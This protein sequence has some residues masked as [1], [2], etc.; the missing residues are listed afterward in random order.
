MPVRTKK[1]RCRFSEKFLTSRRERW[2]EVGAITGTA[3]IICSC[4]EWLQHSRLL[5]YIGKIFICMASESY[6]KSINSGIKEV[7]T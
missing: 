6:S 4:N 2:S 7:W 3:L 1:I 5:N